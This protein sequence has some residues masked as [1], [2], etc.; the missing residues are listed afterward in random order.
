[1]TFTP[2]FE[3]YP[4][5][6]MGHMATRAVPPSHWPSRLHI[7]L[8]ARPHRN[9]SHTFDDF[10]QNHE[11]TDYGAFRLFLKILKDGRMYIS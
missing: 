2:N 6:N 11:F 9:T 5:F 4:F 7:I 10:S 8:L 1:M 3:D